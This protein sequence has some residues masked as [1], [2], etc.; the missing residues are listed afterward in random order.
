MRVVNLLQTDAFGSKDI[1]LFGEL[2]FS[3]GVLLGNKVKFIE[4]KLISFSDLLI[5]YR[6]QSSKFQ[7]LHFCA[8]R[9]PGYNA[10]CS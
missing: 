2:F 1:L 10:V 8:K 3:V 5:T 4:K 6:S 7:T 9:F